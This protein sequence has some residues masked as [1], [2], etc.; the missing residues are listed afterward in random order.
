MKSENR[1]QFLVRAGIGSAALMVPFGAATALQKQKGG[2]KKEEEVSPT[3]DLMREHGLLNRILLIYDHSEARLNQN[4][5]LD[6]GVLASAA[7]IIKRFVEQYHEKLEE[8]YLFPRFRKAGKLT[9]LVSV[10]LAQHEAGRQVTSRI[11]QLANASTMKNAGQRKQLSEQLHAFIRMYRPHEAREDTVL[12]PALHGIVSKNEFD[13]L[14]D[15]FE[16][17]EDQLFGEDGFEHMVDKVAGL[18]KTLGIYDL[19]QFTPK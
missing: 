3:E 14:G 13:S 4:Q 15:E 8:N 9:D 19:A 10:L 1:R 2:E 18:E 12:F 17:Q 5:D 16:K 7:D 11:Q 6:P